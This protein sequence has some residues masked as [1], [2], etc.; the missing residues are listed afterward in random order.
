MLSRP[1]QALSK[2]R[3]ITLNGEA[4]NAVDSFT[5]LGSILSGHA[6]VDDEVNIRIAKDSS[7][8]WTI[9]CQRHAGSVEA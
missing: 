7:R 1:W 6:N 4:L 3:S 5:F 2:Q 8:L 9:V